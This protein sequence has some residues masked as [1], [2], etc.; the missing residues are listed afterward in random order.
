M[1]VSPTVK[2]MESNKAQ[3]SKGLQFTSALKSEVSVL[4]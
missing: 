4:I 3:P 1:S 2:E